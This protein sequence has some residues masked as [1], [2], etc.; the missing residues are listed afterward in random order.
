[1][2]MAFNDEDHIFRSQKFQSVLEDALR[3]FSQTPI[4]PLPPSNAFIGPG[5]YGIYYVG[6]FSPYVPLSNINKPECTRPIY[7]GKAVPQGW[8]TG[9]L[10]QVVRK[11]LHGRLAQHARSISQVEEYAKKSGIKQYIE[12]ADFRCRFMILKDAESDLIAPAEAALIRVNNPLWNQAIAGF[13]LHDVGKKRLDQ[14][15]T[16]WDT[17]HPGRSWTRR[18]T[19]PSPDLPTILEIIEKALQNLSSS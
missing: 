9:R 7:V 14:L 17:L 15:R 12:L 3:F 1:M 4:H 6:N 18:L 19:G 16:M 2:T 13:G 8:R 11:D 5:V 10:A